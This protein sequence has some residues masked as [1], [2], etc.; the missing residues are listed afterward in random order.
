MQPDNRLEIY[1]TSRA[2]REELTRMLSQNTLLP[3]MTTIG[4]FEK[5]ALLVPGRTFIDEDTRI[6]LMQEA[7]DF[8]NFRSLNIDREFFSFLKNSRYLFAFFEELA[9]EMTKIDQLRA[10]DTYASYD[11][12]LTILETLLQKYTE[13]LDRK[14][15]VDKIT[16]PSLYKINENYIRSFSQIELHLEGY[17]NRFEF[18][19]FEKIA[20][21][22]PLTIHLHTSRFNQKMT[23]TFAD[24]GFA[25]RTGYEYILDF[26]NRT[27]LHEVKVPEP[28]THYTIDPQ[29]SSIE[30]IAFVKKKLYDFIR[31]GYAPDD[32]AVILPNAS[33]AVLL[34]LF[35][36]ENNFNFAM[37]FPFTQTVIY[38]KLDALYRYFMERNHENYYRIKSLGFDKAQ[39][40][41]MLKKWSSRL[42][43]KEIMAL[44]A[45][46]IPEEENDIYRQF[47]TELA[48][49]KK[50][51]PSLAHYP[52]HKV[53]HLFLNRLSKLSTDD[54]R[55]G[56]I[57]VMEI[58]ETRGITKEALIVVD[59]NEGVLPSISRKDLF[60]SS[61]LREACGLPTPSD[62]EN[63][64]KYYYNRIFDQAKEVAITYL[65]DDQNQPSRFL[66]ELQITQF[67]HT[68][69]DLKHILLPF[70]KPNPHFMKAD[71]ILTYDFSKTPLSASALKTFLD[72]KRKYYFKHIQKYEAFEIPKDQDNE[73]IV[74]ILLHEAL[75]ELYQKEPAWFSE[76]D[77][78]IAL[79]K[80]LYL[81]S[82]TEPALRFLLDQW[83]ELLKPFVQNEIKRFHE[84]FKV[85]TTEK[86]FTAVAEDLELMGNIDRIDI[87]D[88][89]Y[90]IID[91]KSGKIP[92]TTPRTLEKATDFQLQ[93]YYLI[94]QHLGSVEDAYYYSLKEGKLVDEALFDE[95]LDLLYTH[96]AALKAT[97]HNFTMTETLQK[98]AFCPYQKICDRIL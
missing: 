94:T 86:K 26:Q 5:K 33:T 51:L 89:S 78:M 68:H 66:E 55:G 48:L 70:H 4:E 72:C 40:D 6:L 42:S 52:F 41:E 62:R 24:I 38:R 73:R 11:E 7:S 58:L 32:I 17:L 96:L 59:F 85:F 75:K 50:L 61:T 87:R 3:K 19:I 27:I 1:P 28:Q 81:R 2:I 90:T 22:T 82:E 20:A 13:L 79:Q 83:L 21:I 84:G 77:L 23:D 97:E 25:L 34:D 39:T 56:K 54:T 91:Y 44:F 95:K 15:Y 98:C 57:T 16:L 49:F 36:E 64:Q 46:L 14:K 63:L 9:V 88:G 10:Y 76:E 37:G 43:F 18:Q 69:G 60:L 12:H 45:E 74:G 29:Q 93:F 8:S 31:Q 92:A 65:L 35:D 47:A 30:Q 67:H 53:L 80:A 71:L